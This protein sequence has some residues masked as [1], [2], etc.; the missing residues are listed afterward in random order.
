MMKKFDTDGFSKTSKVHASK[1][2]LT[3]A[4]APSFSRTTSRA[5]QT[6]TGATD[7]SQKNSQ[8]KS[9]Q[10]LKPTLTPRTGTPARVPRTATPTQSSS[11]ASKA[12]TPLRTKPPLTSPKHTTSGKRNTDTSTQ[13]GVRSPGSGNAAPALDTHNADEPG[14]TPAK[15]DDTRDEK[16]IHNSSNC[17]QRIVLPPKMKRFETIRR[18]SRIYRLRR[19]PKSRDYKPT[20]MKSNSLM[21]I[22]M[23]KRKPHSWRRSHVSSLR[24]MTLVRVPLISQPLIAKYKRRASEISA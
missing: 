1:K 7:P 11:R 4:K 8:N 15:N 12:G 19:T 18:R 21:N 23:R 5:G 13:N 2:P 16:D 22:G 17:S 6:T 24:L 20:S 9:T 14:E 3:V 10:P